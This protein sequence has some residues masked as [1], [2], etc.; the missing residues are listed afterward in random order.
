VTTDDTIVIKRRSLFHKIV[1]GFLYTLLTGF[2]ILVILLGF[3][4]TSTFRNILRENL[5]EILNDNINGLFSLEKIDGTIFTSLILRN[6]ILTDKVDTIASIKKLELKL[7]PLKILLKQIYIR[8]LSIESANIVLLKDTSGILNISKVFPSSEEDDTTSSD[9][10]FKIRVADLSLSGIN[11]KMQ[12]YANQNGSLSYEVMNSD[13]L[14]VSDLYMK[15]NAYASI[16]DN[17]Y[18]LELNEIGFNPNFT[19]VPDLSLSGSFTLN[20]NNIQVA[21]LNLKTRD[22][23]IYL[24]AKID[25]LN[26]FKEFNTEAFQN[27]GVS[28]NLESDNLDFDLLTTFIPPLEILK[29]KVN[30]NL[31]AEGTFKELIINKLDMNYIDTKLSVNGKVSNLDNIDELFI[32][33]T[34]FNSELNYYNVNSLLPSLDLPKFDGLEKVYFDTLKYAGSPFNFKG[35][36]A[37]RLESGSIN[38]DIALDYRTSVMKYDVNLSSKNIELNPIFD[39][40]I[41]LNISSSIKGSGTDAD[42]LVGEFNLDADGSSYQNIRFSDFNVYGK[43]ENRFFYIETDAQTDSQ[44]I[45]FFA[46]LNFDDSEKPVYRI[47]SSISNFNMA[48]W[49]G[50]SSFN[51]GLNINLFGM[52]ESFDP[53][54]INAKLECDIQDSELGSR[55]IPNSRI[56]LAVKTN[57]ADYKKLEIKSNFFD[58]VIEGSFRYDTFF[59]LLSKEINR[60]TATVIN[61]IDMIYP[62]SKELIDSYK[63]TMD[64]SAIS[65]SKKNGKKRVEDEFLSASLKYNF[66]LKDFSIIKSLID[67]SEV[68]LEGQIYGSILSDE[69][70]FDFDLNF[71]ADFL[72]FV[73]QDEPYFLSD[74]KLEMGLKHPL[75]KNSFDDLEFDVSTSIRKLFISTEINDIYAD[76]NLSKSIFE[77]NSG[78]VLS[79]KMKTSIIGKIDLTR[80]SLQFNI[81]KLLVN[82]GD[83]SLLNK[84]PILIDYRNESLN[85]K[86]FVMKRGDSELNIK[87]HLSNTGNQDLTLELKNFK[88]YDLSYSL[89]GIHPEEVI[90]GDISLFSTIK[91]TLDKPEI[92]L[93]L[94]GDSISYKK[95]NFGSLKSSFSYTDQLITSNIK[96]VEKVDSVEEERLLINGNF[97]INLSLTAE[98]NRLPEDKEVLLTLFSDNFNLA[99]FGDALPFI[100]KLRGTLSTNIK[101][102][103]NYSNLNRTGYLRLTNASFLVESNNLEYNAGLVLRLEENSLYMDSLLLQNVGIVRNLGSLTGTGKV[104]FEGLNISDMRFAVNGNLTVLSNE[105]RVVSPSFYGNLFVET[106]GEILFTSTKDRSFLRAP[107]IIK[108]ADLYFPQSQTGYSANS[109]NYIYKFVQDTFNLTNRE[110]EIQKLL[111][112]NRDQ[113]KNGELES[114]STFNFDYNISVKI[115]GDSKITFVLAKEANNRLI[116]ELSGNLLYESRQGIQNI[117]GELKLLDGSTLEFFKTFTATGILRFESAITNPYLDIVATYKNFLADTATASTGKEQE[118]AV[119]IKLKGPLQDLSKSFTSMD[120]NIAVYYGSDAIE[121]DEVST[122]YDKSDAVWF[123]LTG[124]FKNEV[125]PNDQSRVSVTATAL[126][127]SLLGGVLNA[128]LG[129]YIKTLDIRSAGSSTK[130]NLSGRFKNFRYTIG[131]TTNILQ[132]FSAANIRI[133]YPI[134]QNLIIRVERKEA[135]TETSSQNIMINELGLR[136]KFEF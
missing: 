61:K 107:I 48:T 135:L 136:Y 73:V 31:Q 20:E 28:V 129:D 104:D 133:E 45:S 57:E 100:D 46:N 37:I 113:N 55:L 101:L 94:T 79:D 121:N 86:Q 74:A 38:G 54:K 124:K 69:K 2:I 119:K 128:Y 23:K 56:E 67:S 96:F 131:G 32:D 87:G 110:L 123:I 10:P 4:Q 118:V 58:G 60:T 70:G 98:G 26:I 115:E 3:S 19:F 80:D 15:L 14:R 97:P 33:V 17:E 12:T 99:A 11:F 13:D 134:I 41:T 109:G 25:R 68:E 122:Q 50:D 111:G 21:N 71:D 64:M 66:S 125:T 105:S 102:V 8:S 29:G 9:F 62:L 22:T 76:L 72:K 112:L 126:A 93:T 132:D 117:Q 82:Y 78:V 81:S 30:A 127:G 114:T 85:F 18:E 103:G 7:S 36:Y 88:G 116:A 43:V 120:N 75:N 52:G 91:G 40:P 90:D 39:I 83:F 108:Q 24:S 63:S 130:I 1:N 84:N 42:H 5:V 35:R 65:F 59:S 44:K 106:D 51:S 77:I 53:E 27:A 34:L 89:L 16:S 6:A 47:N 92:I 49:F 95:K